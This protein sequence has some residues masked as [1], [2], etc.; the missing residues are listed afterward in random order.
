MAV[1]FGS[2][3]LLEKLAIGGMAEIYLA[4]STKISGVEKYLVIK[5][6]LDKFT[7]SQKLLDL[8]TNE[9]KINMN[10]SHSNIVSIFD[11]GLIDGKFF[12]AIEYV[13]GINVK[14][15]IKDLSDS[16]MDYLEVSDILYIVAA[17]AKGLGYAHRCKEIA[18]GKGLEIIHKD[19]S[20]DNI[21]IDTESNVKV[22]DFGIAAVASEQQENNKDGKFAYMSPEQVRGLKL[23]QAT[24]IFSLGIVLWELL[25][26]RRLYKATTVEELM[27]KAQNAR[28]PEIS[29]VNRDIDFEL[30]EIVHKSL[31]RDPDNRYTDMNEFFNDLNLY[32]NKNFPSYSTEKLKEKVNTCYQK[33]KDHRS[34]VIS[35]NQTNVSTNMSAVGQFT[36][37][38]SSQTG[39]GT[40]TGYGTGTGTGYGT[41]TGT[42]GTGSDPGSNVSD[43]GVYTNADDKTE[44]A[45]LDQIRQQRAEGSSG[46]RGSRT[47]TRRIK[48]VRRIKKIKKG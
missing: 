34:K 28:I 38:N 26:K 10:M 20:P 22:I 23:S 8:F 6:I 29:K 14:Q 39:N 5:R 44:I 3:L 1:H 30:S 13:Q 43:P 31:K 12:I 25:T 47:T 17:A 33:Y 48:R 21:M 27:E 41:G 32:L 42:G 46:S 4:K 19:V 24:D 9:A 16:E 35:D 11:F 36:N 40:G 15:L 18:T 37:F 7:H 45:D 2:Y